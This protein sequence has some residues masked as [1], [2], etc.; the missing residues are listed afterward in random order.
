MNCAACGHTNPERAKFCLECGTPFA[1]RCASCG[2]ELP[3]AAKF[4]LECGTPTSA[5]PRSASPPAAPRTDTRKVVTI[6]FADLVG[7][8]ALH[9]RL[10]RRVRAAL[11]GVVLRR[12]ARRGRVAR[13]H[14]HAAARATA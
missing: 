3:A 2:V 1:S 5:A 8:T 4:C 6:V 13:R 9:E 7:S 11:H 12:D 10:E 14:R